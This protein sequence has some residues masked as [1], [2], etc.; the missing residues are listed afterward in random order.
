[1][2]DIEV[3]PGTELVLPTGTVVDLDKPA[4][5]AQ[6]LADI[7][8]L[9]GQLRE[10]R[11]DLDEILLEEAVRLGK[12][13]MHF[14][15]IT[16]EISGGKAIEWDLDELG[17]L[18]AAGLP[19]ERYNELVR[20]NVSYSVDAREATRIGG[21]NPAYKAIIDRARTDRPIPSR[22]SVKR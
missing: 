9:E 4:E 11:R 21:A 15:G 10:V 14:E 16:V 8:K 2:T 22:V 1:M 20:A 18:A 6:A 7:R 19:E 13:T 17:K 5:V 12:K 3:R